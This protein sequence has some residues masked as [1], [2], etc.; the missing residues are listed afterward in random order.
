[1][2]LVQI[3]LTEVR[4][5]AILADSTTEEKDHFAL[6]PVVKRHLQALDKDLSTSREVK[7]HREPSLSV[8]EGDHRKF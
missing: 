3:G 6:W 1:V 2:F 4:E 8:G 5:V 7:A